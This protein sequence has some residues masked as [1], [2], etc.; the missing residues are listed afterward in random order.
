MVIGIEARDTTSFS[1]ICGKGVM[2]DVRFQSNKWQGIDYV[3]LEAVKCIG[4]KLTPVL[5]VY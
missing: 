4:N 2:L 3:N 5:G 1:C